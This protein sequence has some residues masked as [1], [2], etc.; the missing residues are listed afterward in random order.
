M[1]ASDKCCCYIP[2]KYNQIPTQIIIPRPPLI[3]PGPQGPPGTQGPIGLTGLQ[4]PVGLTGTQGPIGLTGL[5]G[6]IGPIGPVGLTGTQGPI[7]LTGLQGPIGPIGL[8]GTQG[9]IGP[10]GLTGTQ[11]PIGL[12]GTQG[13]I[14]LTG[15]QGP[16]GQSITNNNFTWG[17][18]TNTQTIVAADTF[19]TIIF[20]STPEINGW[21]YNNGL[22][23]CIQTG[24]YLVSYLVI[25]SS[26]GGSRIASIRGAI[27]NIQVAGSANTQ[28]FQSASSNQEWNNYFI[29][30]VVLGETFT[31][32][33]AGNS[34][35][36]VSIAFTAAIAGE[37]PVS[38]SIT[39][40]RIL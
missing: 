3:L 1:C 35:S 36:N 16:P 37:T 30:S 29:M 11:G 24:K 27:D 22:F 23:T 25:M 26:I 9:P 19:E 34:A 40:I 21:I 4:G 10:I 39:I 28:A 13:P 32:Q 18:K 5:Q 31:L 7:G 8:T 6:P 38:S 2:I 33:F 20:S 14:G 17:I 15:T 12:T